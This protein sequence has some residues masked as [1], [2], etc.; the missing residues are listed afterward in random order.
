MFNDHII[1]RRVRARIARSHVSSI[2]RALTES[3]TVP[4]DT[5]YPLG[6]DAVVDI[7]NQHAAGDGTHAT[8]YPAPA[9]HADDPNGDLFAQPRDDLT[10]DAWQFTY[11]D[12]VVHAH[13]SLHDRPDST[14]LCVTPFRELG[15]ALLATTSRRSER[16]FKPIW[17]MDTPD[18]V[19]DEFERYLFLRDNR[20]IRA[21]NFVAPKDINRI[22][23]VDGG[24]VADPRWERELSVPG[25]DLAADLTEPYMDT[26]YTLR[27]K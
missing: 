3:T 1:A 19:F 24:P 8:L 7:I 11:T 14:V 15:G 9:P 4:Y 5:L 12:G 2:A 23:H 13:I 17:E 6:T 26:N 10:C 16:S 27:R 25:F 22:A 18:D 21:W 20:A